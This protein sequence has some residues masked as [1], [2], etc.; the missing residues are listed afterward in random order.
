M[1]SEWLDSRVNRCGPGLRW[2]VQEGNWRFGRSQ[3]G[4]LL[5]HLFLLYSDIP[6]LLLLVR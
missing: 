6:I 1:V 2:V 4:I 3:D 5:L